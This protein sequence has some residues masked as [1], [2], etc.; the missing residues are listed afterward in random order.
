MAEPLVT[1]LSKSPPGVTGSA[2][3]PEVQFGVK[4]MDAV[5]VLIRRSLI[6]NILAQDFH[7]RSST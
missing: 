3:S 4:S 7:R 1:V 2:E 6:L 5:G